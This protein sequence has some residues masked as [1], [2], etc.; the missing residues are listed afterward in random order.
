MQRKYLSSLL[1]ILVGCFL[2]A[3]VSTDAFAQQDTTSLKDIFS[4]F[5]L[6]N[7]MDVRIV[8]VSKKEEPV[9]EAPLSSTVLTAEEIKNAGATS[10]MEALR[11]VPGVIVREQTPGN[12]DIH[13]RGFDAVNPYQPQFT[14]FN[15]ITLVM[16][17]NRIVYNPLFGGTLWDLLPVSIDDVEKI[18]VVRGPASALYG[19]NAAAGVI[20]I[21]TKKPNLDA[22]WHGSTYSQVGTY[23]SYLLNAAANYASEDK[24]WGVR[25]SGYHDYRRRHY[26]DY[27]TFPDVYAALNGDENY[28]R[29]AYRSTPYL[30]SDGQPN[31]NASTLFPDLDKSMDRYSLHADATYKDGALD[32][33]FSSGF[34]RSWVQRPYL[35][36]SSYM[37]TTEENENEYVHIYG[38]FENLTFSADYSSLRNNTLGALDY[39]LHSWNATVDYNLILSESASFKPGAAIQRY[40][41]ISNQSSAYVSYSPIVDLEDFEDGDG[42]EASNTFF[43]VFGRF[44]YSYKRFRFVAGLRADKYEYPDRIFVSSQLLTTVMPSN[45]VLLRASYGRSGR[46]PFAT[47]LF[48]NLNPT[49]T[50]GAQLISNP[51]KKELLTVDVFEIGSRIKLSDKW[52][53]DA[54][55][56]Y[57]LA[58]DFES[59][60]VNAFV[61]LTEEGEVK[62]IVPQFE[63]INGSYNAKQY[64]GTITLKYIPNE[65]IQLSGFVTVQETRVDNYDYQNGFFEN[66]ILPASTTDSSF[67]VQATP[68]FYGGM[69]MT[70]KPVKKWQLNLNGYFYDSQ[71]FTIAEASLKTF[72]IKGNFLLNTVVSYELTDKVKLFVNARNLIG[73]N[74]RQYA[75]SDRIKMTMLGGVSAQF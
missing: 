3:A 1:Q 71:V 48:A 41:A 7:L 39:S 25:V 51:D 52:L 34:T 74:K 68:T 36:P 14:R 9:F 47:S 65:T 57:A 37:L 64:G 72:K 49:E 60:A 18:E 20:N 55:V 61:D 56:F 30:G 45:D 69:N 43:S 75:M 19:P 46:A 44:D 21:I 31:S 54:E 12:Y 62:D 11:L 17:N 40:T 29:S 23:H 22:G 35:A 5:S 73:G 63:Y 33:N 28:F 15:T 32:L 59:V 10:I 6:K 66:A 2:T 24:K 26:V 16:I 38:T 53:L 58:D 42:S 4:Q 70:F 50:I 13:I 8:T 67:V 27:Y